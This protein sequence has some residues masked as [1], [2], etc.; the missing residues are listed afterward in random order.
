[1]LPNPIS[2]AIVSLLGG[3][4]VL[5]LA[6]QAAVA[7]PNGPPPA[8]VVT[9][10]AL[11]REIVSGYSFVGSA[12]PKRISTVGS[13]VDGRV[14]DFKVNLGDRVKKGD[15]LAQL[16]TKQ[17]EIELEGAKA[18]LANR[19]AAIDEAKQGRKEEIDQSQARLAGK[20]AVRDYA[21]ARLDRYKKA[22]N[23]QVYT[24]EQ[25][26]EIYSAAVQADKAY[27]EEQIALD[28]LQKG[29]REEVLRQWQAKLEVQQQVIAGIEDQLEKHTIKAPFDG[30]IVAES[31][32]NGQWLKRGDLVATVAELDQIDVEIQVLENYIP[33]VKVG[34]E[35]RVEI[36][37][38]PTEI[39]IGHVAEIVPQADL[40]TR[41]FPV[42]VRL[43][44][45]IV[46][47]QPLIKAG[48]FAR[49]TLAVGRTA[50][51]LLVPKDA[52]V[53][54]GPTPMVFVADASGQDARGSRTAK[55]RPV[56]VQ[57]GAAWEGYL[58]V[59]GDL[60]PGESVVVQGNERLRPGQAVVI[61]REQDE[62]AIKTAARTNAE[63]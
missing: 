30:Y 27:V 60:K 16:L 15:P 62:P 54:G 34:D 59:T 31:T 43:D 14:V 35:V 36:T 21:I 28:L 49:A 6:A 19:Q 25:V 37:S 7:Q 47:G 46:D 39:L 56:S 2:R 53:L 63:R 11:E 17:L 5:A 40:R 52:I 10:K 29:A 9:A 22:S 33:N 50:G 23:K 24:Q 44:N 45:K 13:A 42:R 61:V 32:E 51:A 18:E 12:M 57:L 20:K 1:M 41:N 26:E 58:Q 55:A 48:M 4:G 8:N 3:L 38:L